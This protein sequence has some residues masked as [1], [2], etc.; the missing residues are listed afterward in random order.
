[1][2]R[3]MKISRA[4]GCDDADDLAENK[5][6]KLGV[7]V[8]DDHSLETERDF[9]S[10]SLAVL[11]VSRPI[12]R[13]GYA[14]WLAIYHYHHHVLVHEFS[15]APYVFGQRLVLPSATSFSFIR[16]LINFDDF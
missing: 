13:G 5:L 10:I 11:R 7:V 6:M 4:Q 14:L 12:G 16:V 2:P 8:M 1:M 9:Q 15:F 3:L